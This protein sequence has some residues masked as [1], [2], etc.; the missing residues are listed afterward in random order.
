MFCKFVWDSL[1]HKHFLLVKNERQ[2]RHQ[3]VRKN[4]FAFFFLF[5]PTDAPAMQMQ[6]QFKSTWI[7]KMHTSQD[8]TKLT[9]TSV[10][11]PRKSMQKPSECLPSTGCCTLWMAFCLTLIERKAVGWRLQCTRQVEFNTLRKWE[12]FKMVTGLIV[13][14]MAKIRK[15][16]CRLLPFFRL[17]RQHRIQLRGFTKKGATCWPMR[18][19]KT[20]RR[21]SNSGDGVDDLTIFSKNKK[22]F[23]PTF[24]NN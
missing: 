16:D 18:V 20:R 3:N 11:M 21:P 22:I 12:N 8:W 19:K 15:N 13:C 17:F 7:S 23:T 14:N 2:H 6:Q 10:T 5:L 24:T 1:L 4:F 9:R